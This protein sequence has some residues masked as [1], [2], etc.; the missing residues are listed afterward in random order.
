MTIDLAR[1]VE[2]FL[3]EQVRTGVCPDASELVN[4]V[5]RSGGR[6]LPGEVAADMGARFGFDFSRIR[7]FSDAE[8]ADSS[9][10]N[11]TNNPQVTALGPNGAQING[12]CAPGGPMSHK[13]R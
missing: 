13:P 6:P 3:Q 2:A 10:W 4:D 5:L 1:D 12:Y 7:I 8:A 9:A 11:T